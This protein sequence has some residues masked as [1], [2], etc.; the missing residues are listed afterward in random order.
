MK[1]IIVTILV[2]LYYTFCSYQVA[3]Q[4]YKI[5]QSKIDALAN[6]LGIP[7]ALLAQSLK[8]VYPGVAEATIN[9]KS[10]NF[11]ELT[12]IF[13]YKNVDQKPSFNG[14]DYN[15]FVKWILEQITPPKDDISIILSFWIDTDGSLKDASVVR[16]KNA[17]LNNKV[18]HVAS[19][20]PL[21][22]PGRKDGK[23][24]SVGYTI[25]VDF[26]KPKP[27]MTNGVATSSAVPSSSHNPSTSKE[28]ATNSNSQTSA[29]GNLPIQ[30]PGTTWGYAEGTREYGSVR[31][32]EFLNGSQVR[33][34]GTSYVF[35]R[36]DGFSF[37]YE[38]KVINRGG[39]TY[40]CIQEDSYNEKGE[41]STS[42]HYYFMSKGVDGYYLM[43]SGISPPVCFDL[44]K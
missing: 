42:P 29:E 27:I 41:K 1:R 21:W 10:F 9:G 16:G 8:N 40:V 20:S 12:G 3:A 32:L 28:I 26:S 38:Y 34:F 19:S 23:K 4:S 2:F 44:L 30:L 25:P 31:K 5:E 17:D 35:G 15:D 37:L 14:G 33:Y 22:E 24:V 43:S 39:E 11:E 13:S 36:P 18:I 7:S 6:E